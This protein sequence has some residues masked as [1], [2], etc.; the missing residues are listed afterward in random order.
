MN[1]KIA[2]WTT[3][4]KQTRKSESLLDCAAK[5]QRK[6]ETE[7][8]CNAFKFSNNKNCDLSKVYLFPLIS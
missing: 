1:I 6:E 8:L 2:S 3:A 4:L 5:C 7:S